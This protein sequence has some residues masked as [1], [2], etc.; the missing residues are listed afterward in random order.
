MMRT[1]VVVVGVAPLAEHHRAEAER[2][3]LDAGAAEGS[4][5]HALVLPDGLSLA[6]GAGVSQLIPNPTAYD[7]PRQN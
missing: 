2:A 1:A 4:Q 5:F 7:L 3:D 6:G